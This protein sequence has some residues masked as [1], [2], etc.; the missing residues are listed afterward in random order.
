V[1]AYESLTSVR[2]YRKTFPHREAVDELRK[3]AGTQ[4]DPGLLQTFLE[5]LE[6]FL[7]GADCPPPAA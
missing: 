4:F 6:T 1:D 3:H 5:M 7:P 2:P